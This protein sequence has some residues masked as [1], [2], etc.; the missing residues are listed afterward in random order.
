MAN[1]QQPQ[2]RVLIVGGSVAGLTLAHCLERANIEYLILEKGDDIA[3]QVGASIGI[4]PNGGRILE[5]LGLFGEIER[6]IEPLHQANISYPDGFCFS[7]VYPKVLGDRFGYPVAFLDRQKF[8]QIAYEGLTKKHNV[9]TRKRVVEVRQLEHGITVAVADGTEYEVDLV[10]GADGVHSRVR[11]MT[12]EYVCVFGISSA[13]P[14]LEIS[15]QIN[16]IY[17]HL[18]ILTIHGRHGRVFWF[19]IQKLDRKYVYPDVPRFSDEDAVQL[20]ERVKH[21]RFWKDICVGDL[22]KNREV[23]SMTALEEGL[24][25]TW[26]HERMVLIG[27]SV[28]KM[29]PNFGQ[30]ANCA[31]EDAAALSS[32]LH[33][34]INAR[35]VCK[36]SNSQVQHLL[37]QYQETRYSRMVGMCRTAASV[38]RIQARDGILNTV[39]GRYWAPYAGNLPADLASKVMAD[40][41]VV[42]FLPLPGRSGPGWEMYRRKGKREQIQWVLIIFSLIT[43]GG[44]CI[45]LQSNASYVVE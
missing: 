1:T 7:N 13:I 25:E 19:V 34:L 10:V 33:D 12:V 24:F 32:L 30:G 17:D 31:I 41:E 26:H 2:F 38:S 27:D 28:H 6:V 16:G 21:V 9:L 3:P 18:S 45:W 39:F 23:S 40:A 29:T 22:W 35:G 42:S 15:E 36:P 43:L 11:S 20:F 44:L 37:Q 8:L 4:M 14:G 5:Q